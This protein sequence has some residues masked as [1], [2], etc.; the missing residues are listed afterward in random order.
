MR[1]LRSGARLEHDVI[2]LLTDAE[3]TGLLGAAAF[4]REHPWA[5]DV[6]VVLNFEARG[7]GGRVFMFET[8]PGNLDVVR[9]LRDV[10]E[11]SATSLMVMVYRVLPND[12]DLTELMALGR[13]SMNFAFIDGVERYHTAQDDV[14][15]LDQRSV[16]HHGVQALALA[17]AF[18]SGPLPRPATG[19]AVFFDAPFVGLVVYPEPLARIPAVLALLL[20]V[21]LVVRVRATTPRWIRDVTLG[22]AGA[23]GVAVLGVL[24]ATALAV[25]LAW[26]HAALGL[27]G[28]AAWNDPYAAAVV[29]GAGLAAWGAWWVVRRLTTAPAAHVGALTML[30]VAVAVVTWLAPGASYVLVWP[31]LFALVAATVAA[32]T[33][34]TTL[35][36]TSR[37]MS[38]LVTLTFVVPLV[39]LLGVAMGIQLPGAA[40]AGLLT[41]VGVW[42]LAPHLDTERTTTAGGVGEQPDRITDTPA[43]LPGS[44]PVAAA[45]PPGTARERESSARG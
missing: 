44:P 27:D 24:A 35:R 21:V 31:V 30:A 42:L 13:P 4:V 33:T 15:H 7:T 36:A 1:A 39:Y 10:P 40:A 14:A 17:R 29:A 2:L 19:D 38:S 12:T 34:S 6:E 41:A 43:A 18:A 9:V 20:A 23:V 25:A 3:E 28:R 26:M 16:Q 32:L 11:V 45:A 22:A 5:R 8:A 37:W